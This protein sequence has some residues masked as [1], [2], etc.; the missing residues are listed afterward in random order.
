MESG[1]GGQLLFHSPHSSQWEGVL[2]VSM[3]SNNKTHRSSWLLF[4]MDYTKTSTGKIF[5]V[6]D[7][8]LWDVLLVMH[9][10]GIV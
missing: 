1:E 9:T 3:A 7:R 6:Q 5:T 10:W 2:L 4:W 8:E